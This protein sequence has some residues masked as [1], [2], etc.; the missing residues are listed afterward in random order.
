MKLF[1]SKSKDDP[2]DSKSKDESVKRLM[3]TY[4]EEIKPSLKA[5]SQAS[6][7]EPAFDLDAK[8]WRNC[9]QVAEETDEHINETRLSCLYEHLEKTTDVAA[10]RKRKLLLTGGASGSSTLVARIDYSKFDQVLFPEDL[11]GGSDKIEG[12]V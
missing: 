7:D 2:L 3:R 6:I 4:L 11:V 5:R 12:Y 8:T 1:D 10:T 9:H